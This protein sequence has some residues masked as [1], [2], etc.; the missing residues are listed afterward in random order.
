ML[1]LHVQNLTE[2]RQLSLEL[3]CWEVGRNSRMLK[4]KSLRFFVLVQVPCVQAG[5]FHV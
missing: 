3:S 1:D 2:M 4:R 5:K